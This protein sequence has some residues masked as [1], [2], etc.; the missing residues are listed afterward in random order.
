M[1]KNLAYF[2]EYIVI[3]NLKKNLYINTNKISQNMTLFLKTEEPQKN[4]YN[5]NN[6]NNYD[7]ESS[8]SIEFLETLNG[9]KLV[10]GDK[11]IEVKTEWSTHLGDDDAEAT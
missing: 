4:K 1:A 3:L 6:N 7:N 5:E 2:K 10:K 9:D 8:E 11:V